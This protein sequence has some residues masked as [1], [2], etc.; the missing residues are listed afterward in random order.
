MTF[1]FRAFDLH[2]PPMIIIKVDPFLAGLANEPRF[3]ELIAKM[4]L[5]PN[6]LPAMQ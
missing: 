3:A 5:D 1:L 6:Q 2:K 4:K